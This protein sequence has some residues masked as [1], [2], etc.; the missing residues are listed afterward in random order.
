VVN[1]ELERIWKEA[2]V[3]NVRYCLEGLR[4]A[5]ETLNLENQS[6]SQAFN[7]PHPN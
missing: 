3:I 5:M 7:K 6:S 2:V 1:N 4:K